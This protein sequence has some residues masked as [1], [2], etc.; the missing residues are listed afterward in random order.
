[1]SAAPNRNTHKN[2]KK[3]PRTKL[4]VAGKTHKNN[5]KLNEI[6]KYRNKKARKLIGAILN[7][8]LL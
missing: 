3:G 4:N 5:H 8:K 2:I 7:I 6:G 1:M